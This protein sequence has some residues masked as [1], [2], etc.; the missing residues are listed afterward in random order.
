MPEPS[1]LRDG[2]L[3]KM[4]GTLQVRPPSA[5]RREGAGP[6]PAKGS[7]RDVPTRAGP[8]YGTTLPSLG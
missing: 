3:G 6:A 7:A 5:D 8:Y 1:R 2:L 4:L